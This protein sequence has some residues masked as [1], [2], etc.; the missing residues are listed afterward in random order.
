MRVLT[1]AAE[2]WLILGASS[3]IARAFARLAA[4]SGADVLLAGRDEADMAATAAD[5]R[6]RFEGRVET[7][8]FDALDF[9]SHPAFIERARA[10]AGTGTLNL[11]L[12]FGI[13]PAQSEI[14]ASPSL[15]GT[16]IAANY[17]AA[18]HLLQFAA[19][20]FEAQK[21]GRSV[22]LGSVAGERGRLGNYVYGSAKAGLHAYLQGLRAR[23][24]RAGVTV[25]TVKPGPTDTAMT[26]GLQKLPLLVPPETVAAAALKAALR[27][28][29]V[30]YVPFPWWPIMTILRAIPE[31]IFKKLN[32]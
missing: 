25:T 27:G 13:M 18:A 9:G 24:W 11:F 1:P 3:A 4:A 28:T 8:T 10:F 14:D 15:V 6:V 30:V 22:V 31:R 19:P 21:R 2:T 16:V 5:L 26:F 17:T 29:E 12:A 20:L 7:A 23:L 32:I